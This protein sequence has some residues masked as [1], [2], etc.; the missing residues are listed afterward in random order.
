MP[1]MKPVGAGKSA[2]D[3]INPS[4]RLVDQFVHLHYRQSGRV[5]RRRTR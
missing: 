4:L 2:A 5:N 1:M 3:A